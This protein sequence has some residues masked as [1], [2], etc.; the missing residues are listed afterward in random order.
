MWSLPWTTSIMARAWNTM[1][2]YHH[3][4]LSVHKQQNT[5]KIALSIIIKYT[6]VFLLNGFVF[7]LIKCTLE[8]V[9]V[10][11]NGVLHLFKGAD[12]DGFSIQSDVKSAQFQIHWRYIQRVCRVKHTREKTQRLMNDCTKYTDTQEHIRACVF[13]H[14]L[15]EN[16]FAVSNRPVIVLSEEA[17]AHGLI[18][19]MKHVDVRVVENRTHL[20]D[21]ELTHL[22]QLRWTW[23]RVKNL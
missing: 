17:D 8:C 23:I 10:C 14:V 6:I 13:L 5:E 18:H 11:S 7:Y 9:F 22:Q 21:D 19:H 12:A 4:L 16:F 2:T 15:F 20:I 1:I 3:S